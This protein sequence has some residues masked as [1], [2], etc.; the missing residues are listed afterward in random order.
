[1]EGVDRCAALPALDQSSGWHHFETTF[2]LDARATGLRMFLYA[3]GDAAGGATTVAEYRDPRIELTAPYVLT[4][5][6]RAPAAPPP[7]V[8]WRKTGPSSYVVDVPATRQPF[9]LGLAES[10]AQD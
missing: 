4:L 10:Y 5:L 3:D 1:E 9:L 2:S 8:R 7:A 6:Q